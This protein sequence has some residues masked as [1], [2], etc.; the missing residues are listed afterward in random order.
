[1]TLTAKPFGNRTT[2]WLLC[3]AM[4][5][6]FLSYGQGKGSLPSPTLTAGSESLVPD[7][8]PFVPRGLRTLVLVGVERPV[9]SD[10]AGDAVDPDPVGVLE[11][12]RA[13]L[14]TVTEV[15]SHVS[16]LR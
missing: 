4:M 10:D 12:W 14:Q 16:H 13:V 3:L 5:A 11:D 7:E 9:I 1:M 8:G 6:S 15:C 2:T